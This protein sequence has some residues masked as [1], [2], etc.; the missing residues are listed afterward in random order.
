MTGPDLPPT[1][2]LEEIPLMRAIVQE[3]LRIAAPV[4][5]R[6]MLIA[7]EED[8]RFGEWVIPRGT[9]TSMTLQDILFDPDVFPEPKT[10]D[11]D[12][13]VRAA[14]EGKRL[15]RFLV[16]F[17]KGSRMCIG[18]NVAYAELYIALAALVARFD[19]EFED[20]DMKRDLVVTRDT[21]VGMPSKDSRGVRVKVSEVRGNSIGR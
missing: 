6:P 7:P 18:T 13:W 8:L 11:P 14:Q 15:D 3:G 21:F 9:P 19:F 1:H 5:S 10:F 12:R 2:T 16:T 17:S 4:T 20:F